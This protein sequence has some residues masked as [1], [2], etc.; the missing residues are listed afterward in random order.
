V[1]TDTEE[2]LGIKRSLGIRSQVGVVLDVA[3]IRRGV[4]MAQSLQ[5]DFFSERDVRF[6]QAVS[7][8]VGSVVHR[9]E[10][11]ERASAAAIDQGRRMAAE[12]LVTVLA[13]D[14]RKHITPL[15]AR[16]TMLRRRAQREQH[17][18]NLGDS[19]KLLDD[20]ERLS[21]IISDLLDVARLDQGLFTLSPQPVDV[22]ALAREIAEDLSSPEAEVHVD[23]PPELAMVADPVRL[24]Q[25]LENLLANALEH[26]PE[27]L[28]V[29][30]G[31]M[32]ER[33]TD[34]PWAVFTVTDQGPGVTPDLLPRL[35]ERFAKG[36]RSAGLGLG[37]H[38]AQ[39]I[40][41]AHGGT[42]EVSSTSRSGTTFSVALPTLDVRAVTVAG[43]FD[44]RRDG[45]VERGAEIGHE[46]RLQHDA[47]R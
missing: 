2:L 38:L 42:L 17:A 44:G 47:S 43:D 20:F 13:H 11:A 22:A 27:R 35:F 40:V 15:R 3:G 18:T 34:Q 14:L 33:R 9:V 7:R 30:L 28:G 37:L 39:Q 5:P 32:A 4:L 46:K 24:R 16:L 6:L 23:A 29:A 21:H 31:V 19:A 26:S 25:A 1:D 36:P 10:L 12:E 8:W 45:E 41:L